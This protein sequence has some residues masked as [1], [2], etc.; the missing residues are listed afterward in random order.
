MFIFSP[1]LFLS[2][3][4]FPNFYK[5]HKKETFLFIGI[6]SAFVLY[7]SLIMTNTWHGLV[8]WSAR[9]M[10]LLIPFLLIPLAA[11]LEKTKS[12]LFLSILIILGSIGVFFNLVWLIQDVSWFVWAGMGESKYGLYSLPSF[13]FGYRISPLVLWTF[14]FSQLTNTIF[15]AFTQLQLDI[16]LVKILTPIGYIISF[17]GILEKSW[18]V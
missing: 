18:Y 7:Y 3:F 8:G 6:I 1:I 11:T 12:K 5:K 15:L 4:A 14:E 9:Y 17:V 2:F 13:Q 16:F 10:I